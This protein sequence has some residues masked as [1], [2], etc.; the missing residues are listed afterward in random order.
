MNSSKAG[1]S[2]KPI[3]QMRKLHLFQPK[4]DGRGVQVPAQM[5]KKC[6]ESLPEG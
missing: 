4:P 6:K 5:S 1:V 2:M 3:L